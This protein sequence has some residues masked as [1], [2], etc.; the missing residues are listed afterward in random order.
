MGQV[1]QCWWKICREI[2]VFFSRFEYHTFYVLYPF[3]TYLLIL[4]RTVGTGSSYS[5]DKAAR[6]LKLAIQLDVVSKLRVHGAVPP[7]PHTS[8]WR[9][10]ELSMFACYT[11]GLFVFEPSKR[12]INF[13][14]DLISG[15]EWNCCPLDMNWGT[16]ASEVLCKIVVFQEHTFKKTVVT[17]C[18]FWGGG[19]W[20][21]PAEFLI[22]QMCCRP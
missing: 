5:G 2:N 17:F 20:G 9:D 10:A 12:D 16:P 19:A 4:P 13:R 8:S 21:G 6:G 7:L 18:Y 22:R 15:I 11:L 1:Y 3:L 14:A